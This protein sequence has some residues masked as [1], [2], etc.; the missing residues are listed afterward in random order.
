MN[1]S[2]QDVAGRFS[3][4]LARLVPDNIP[5]INIILWLGF[6]MVLVLYTVISLVLLYHW[7]RYSLRSTRIAF[8]ET[9]YFLVSAVIIFA[10][11]I[12]L[13]LM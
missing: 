3:T 12:A 1:M 10:A 2:L 11:F 4:G 5:S 8:A 7:R 9:V 13:I 6:G